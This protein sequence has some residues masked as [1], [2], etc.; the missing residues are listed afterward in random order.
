MSSSMSMSMSLLE[1]LSVYRCWMI[2]IISGVVK[3]SLRSTRSRF[4]V[5]VKYSVVMMVIFSNGAGQV[6]VLVQDPV[7]AMENRGVMGVVYM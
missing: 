4:S 3:S 5:K 7:E 2:I 6:L 1:S